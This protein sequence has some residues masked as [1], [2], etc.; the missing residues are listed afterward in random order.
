[1]DTIK[2]KKQDLIKALKKNRK[3]HRKI[4][5]RAQIAFRQKWIELLDERLRD[6]KNGT[7]IKAYV[8]IPEPEDHTSDFDTAI[9]MLEWEQDDVVELDR[10]DFKRF[11][12]NQW[13][14]D[15]SFRANTVSYS[16]MLDA[17]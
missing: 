10:R 12:Q 13:D 14:W 15:Q 1:M 2:V 17:E 7:V 4:F 11:V 8:S 9:E 3:K 6:A 5:D 16:A